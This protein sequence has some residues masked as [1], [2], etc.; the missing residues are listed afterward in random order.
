LGRDVRQA[1]VIDAGPIAVFGI[2]DVLVRAFD[3]GDDEPIG[4]GRFFVPRA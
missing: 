3:V 2:P 4:F 1:L